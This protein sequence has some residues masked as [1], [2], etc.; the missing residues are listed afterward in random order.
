MSA[1]AISH[2]SVPGTDSSEAARTV[3][4]VAVEMLNPCFR[5]L[6]K[7]MRLTIM[8]GL[9]PVGNC[10]LFKAHFFCGSDVCATAL[11]T[12]AT[13]TTDTDMG[14]KQTGETAKV[15][16][17]HVNS[18][19]TAE[20]CCR[21]NATAHWGTLAENFFCNHGQMGLEPRVCAKW[22]DSSDSVFARS[23]L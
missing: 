8:V 17:A 7:D 14:Q 20:S 10:F 5:S 22:T 19:C 6:E 1:L 16:L 13:T 15:T 11:P 9:P 12:S 2:G 18:E 21:N 4:R 23:F 3:L